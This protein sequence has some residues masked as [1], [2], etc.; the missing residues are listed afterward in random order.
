[1]PTQQFVF[2]IENIV[3]DVRLSQSGCE[4]QGLVVIDSGA[5]VNV[6]SEWFGE[7]ALEKSDG[8]IRLRGADGI[9]ELEPSETM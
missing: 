4:S 5:S 6:C 7:S 9:T 2:T 8:S 3:N 1:M